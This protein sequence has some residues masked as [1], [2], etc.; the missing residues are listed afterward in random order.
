MHPDQ[1]QYAPDTHGRNECNTALGTYWNCND[2]LV[3]SYCLFVSIQRHSR[4][5]MGK[6]CIIQKMLGNLK[7]EKRV[8]FSL[9]IYCNITFS[10][11]SF[12]ILPQVYILL[13]LTF[14]S[15]LSSSP[16]TLWISLS[17]QLTWGAEITTV[18]ALICHWTLVIWTFP[19]PGY[20]LLF[21]IFILFFNY[22]FSQCAC[23]CVFVWAVRRQ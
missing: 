5:E 18:A 14:E 7:K 8:K 10:P 17:M 15:C 9:F 19:L 21:T 20:C 2:Q 3:D 22:S 13:L 4:H 16:T 1:Y 23:L 6:Y 11:K 12:C